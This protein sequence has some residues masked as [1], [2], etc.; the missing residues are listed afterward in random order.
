MHNSGAT[1]RGKASGRH[2]P[3]KRAIQYSEVS[4]YKTEKLRRTGYPAFAQ[5]DGFM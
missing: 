1:R 5:Y 3:R 2:R 4:G